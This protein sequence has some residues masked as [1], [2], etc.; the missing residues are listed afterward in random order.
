MPSGPFRLLYLIGLVVLSVAFTNSA[1]RWRLERFSD[2]LR[3][4]LRRDAQYSTYKSFVYG[5]WES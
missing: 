3:D 1:S 4:L 2:K 5:E